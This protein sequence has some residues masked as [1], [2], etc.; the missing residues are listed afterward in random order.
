MPDYGAE[1]CCPLRGSGHALQDAGTMRSSEGH[2]MY[3]AM[4]MTD[5][6]QCVA[7]SGC[8]R[9][10]LCDQLMNRPGRSVGKGNSSTASAIP[11]RASSFFDGDSSS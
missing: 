5:H 4:N 2:M 9:G 7:L 6:R 10:K 3:T 11:R 1:S 8:F